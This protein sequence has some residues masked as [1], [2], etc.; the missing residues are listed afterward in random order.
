MAKHR[1]GPGRSTP[2]YH[3]TRKKGLLEN[4]F[5]RAVLIVGPAVAA[6]VWLLIR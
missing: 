6:L 2:S 4:C 5:S 3:P 1:G